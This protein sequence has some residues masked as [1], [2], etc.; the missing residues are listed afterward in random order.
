MSASRLELKVGMFVIVMLGIAAVMTLRFSETG[1]GL[2]KTIPLKLQSASAGNV[3]VDA[4]IQLSGVKIGVVGK[5]TLNNDGRGVV[6]HADIFEEFWHALDSN[7][8]FR[9][10]VTGLMGDEYIAVVP[11]AE[12]GEALKPGMSR[13]CE[14]PFDLMSVARDAQHLIRRVDNSMLT[15]DSAINRLDQTVLSTETLTNLTAAIAEF[16]MTSESIHTFAN[17]LTTNIAPNV[18]LT[19]QKFHDAVSRV[20]TMLANNTNTLQVSL[21]N[22]AQFTKRLDTSASHLE[23]LIATNAPMVSKVF[24]NLT[25]ISASL[26]ISTEKLQATISTN[27]TS[28]D[29]IVKDVAAVTA[30]LKNFTQ[31]ADRIVG[32]LEEG[33]GLAGGLLKDDA[34]RTEFSR[35]MTNLNNAAGNFS[36]LASNLNSR[37]LLYKPPPTNN[38]APP[39]SGRSR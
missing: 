20:D 29:V 16:R 2:T 7:T 39:K 27:Q 6:I 1:F 9:I 12:K 30:N 13:D 38:R 18:D 33:K 31:N 35:L 3:I 23:T 5:I 28:I 11:G 24:T 32:Q 19:V 34:L 25:A 17:N 8:Q 21:N 10:K 4:P 14:A 22:F 26:K 37:G 36:I 15:L